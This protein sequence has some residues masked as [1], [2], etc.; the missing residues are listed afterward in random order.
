MSRIGLTEQHWAFIQPLLPPP[1]P[2]GRPRANDRR[3]IERSFA[4]PGAYRRLL[5]RWERHFRVYRSWFAFAVMLLCAR[6]CATV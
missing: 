2:T 5:I 1:A 4:W 3:T 6:R